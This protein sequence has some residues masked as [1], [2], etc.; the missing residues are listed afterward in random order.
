MQNLGGD[1]ERHTNNE[2][3]T[4]RSVRYGREAFDGAAQDPPASPPRAPQAA[5][6]PASPSGGEPLWRRELPARA[7]G[8]S[9]SGFGAAPREPLRRGTAPARP[10]GGE[11][12]ASPSGG[13]PVWWRELLARALGASTSGLARPP[14]SPSGVVR[15]PR[16]P[17]AWR[18]PR[19]PLRQQARAV[20]RAPVRFCPNSG[21]RKL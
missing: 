6:P 13:E 18:G 2:K 5:S 8:A 7:L 3:F 9:P 12:P 11:P 16:A 19:E 1:N 20:A 14:T 15:P 21:K 17:P 10:S 4:L